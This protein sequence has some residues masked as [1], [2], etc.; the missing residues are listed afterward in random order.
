VSHERRPQVEAI[1]SGYGIDGSAYEDS[2]FNKTLEGRMSARGIPWDAYESVLRTDSEEAVTF[3]GSLRVGYS[4]FFRNPLTFAC[5]EAIILPAII[6]K[7]KKSADK[8][9]RLW[10]AACAGGQEAYSAAMLCDEALSNNTISMTYRIF[11]TDVDSSAL[12]DAQ[13]GIYGL[14]SLGKLSLRRSMEYFTRVSESYSVVP[15]LRA[16]VDFSPFDLVAEQGMCPPI[17]IFGSFDLIFCC[18]ML[19]YY[20]PE[21]QRRIMEKLAV[22]LAPGSYLVT[23][24]AEREILARYRDEKARPQDNNEDDP[25]VFHPAAMHRCARFHRIE[26]VKP[27]SPASHGLV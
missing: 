8:D 13:A 6:E 27:A 20:K 3:A 11:G 22:C 10:S 9:L 23:G 16:V 18:N 24:E 5:L 19:F 1:L 15:R 14:E 17:S 4:E 7:K 12:R 26:P 2:F 21:Y 25:R